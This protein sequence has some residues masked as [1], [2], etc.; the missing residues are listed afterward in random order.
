MSTTISGSTLYRGSFGGKPEMMQ[1]IP[2]R[3]VSKPGQPNPV[4][5]VQ[6]L[7]AA[8]KKD[9]SNKEPRA[10]RTH[11][12]VSNDSNTSHDLSGLINFQKDLDEIKI[13]LRD[14][15]TKDDL[16]EMTKDLVKTSDLENIV[17]GIVKKLFSKFFAL[18]SLLLVSFFFAANKV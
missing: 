15:T 5:T 12:E 2:T 7:L 13:S 18:G 14:V 9:T 4:K 1:I 10:K 16:N 11:S 8:K 17:T 6:T 3:P